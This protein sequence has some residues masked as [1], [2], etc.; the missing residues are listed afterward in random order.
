MAGIKSPWL[1]KHSRKH[2]AGTDFTFQVAIMATVSGGLYSISGIFGDRLG[3]QDY[4]YGIVFIAIL[5][6]IP[7]SGWIKSLK[8]D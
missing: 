1:I 2:L 7:I 4:L 8:I 5:C 6:L 3:Y